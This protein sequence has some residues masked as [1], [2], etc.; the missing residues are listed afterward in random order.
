MTGSGN[1]ALYFKR[2]IDVYNEVCFQVC[3]DSKYRC[4][5]EPLMKVYYIGSAMLRIDTIILHPDDV[6]EIGRLNRMHIDVYAHLSMK[7]MIFSPLRY[8]I[9]YPVICV[10]MRCTHNVL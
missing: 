8:K 7:Y 9:F 10:E 4:N 3:F 2:D 6:T 5:L 1:F